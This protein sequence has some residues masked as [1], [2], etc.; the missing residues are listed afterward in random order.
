MK[1]IFTLINLGLIFLISHVSVSAFYGYITTR[2]DS[3]ESLQ[4]SR[5][6]THTTD[7]KQMM[8]L[9]EYA[10]VAQRDLFKTN[11]AKPPPAKK[12]PPPE[13]ETEEIQVTKLKLELKGT[14]TGTGSEP[15]AVINKKGDARQMLYAEGDTI[16]KARIK[17]I[18][19]GKVILL[20]DGKE[21]ILLMENRKSPAS[22]PEPAPVLSD[23]QQ[24]EPVAEQDG[25][26]QTVNLSW[27]D[28]AQLRERMGDIRKEI[29]IRPH[30]NKG[31]MD[32][33]RVT[34]IKKDSL[35]YTKLGLRN[36]D[37]ISGVNE[38]DLQSAQ[39]VAG[40]YEGFDLVAGQFDSDVRIKRNGNAG[41]IKYSIK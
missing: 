40:I 24:P 14:I 20:V 31:K 21:E 16:E 30:F 19:T 41:K 39:D 37:V 27:E 12:I 18:V 10:R 6:G 4:M 36:G 5:T 29:R 3:A 13:K 26:E 17:T 25:F 15:L 35:L 22:S 33:F 8:P 32:G 1:T 11:V 23:T 38:K 34:N 28:V 9:S 2:L 7:Q